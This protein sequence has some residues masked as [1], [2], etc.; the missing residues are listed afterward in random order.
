MNYTHPLRALARACAFAASTLAVASL[1]TEGALADET[2]QSP[3][4]AKI[5]GQEDFVYVWTLGQEGVGD[6]QDKLVTVD[7]SPK[8]PTYGKVVSTLSVGGRNEAHHSGFTDD[9]Q[10]LWAA[11]LDTSKMFIFDVHTDPAKP[12]LIKT[13]TDFVANSGGVV[14]PHSTYALPGRM[15]ITGLSNNKD[16]GGR[17]GLVEYTNDGEYI[18]THWTPTDS[19]LEGALKSGKYADGYGYDVRVLPRRN[20]MLTSSF[21]GWSNYMMD[22]GKML[23]D[24]EAMK[25]FGNTVVQWNLHSKQPKKVFDVPGAPL[26]IRCAWGENHNYCFTST[27][28]TS[29]IWLIYEDDQ[30]EW[31]AKEVAD[32]GDPSK[33]PLPVDISISSDD[34]MLWVNTF[35]DGKTRAFDITDPFKPKPVYEQKIGAQVNMVSS[36]WDGKRLYYTSSLLANWD[37]KGADNE[38]FLKGYAWDGKQLTQKFA[39]DF[40]REKLGRAHQMVFNAYSLYSANKPDNAEGVLAKK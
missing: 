27:A 20:L 25:R 24:P 23:N 3:Y 33:V 15:I 34:R 5:V 10:F 32:V 36:S 14:G 12:K 16:H 9:R 8:S 40:T 6:E 17:T 7:V 4:M 38:Q 2:C 29:K 1:G 11:S 13:I 37:K 18:A 19:D 31:Q 30:G 22:F 35:M 21:T 39:I 28:L 26:E